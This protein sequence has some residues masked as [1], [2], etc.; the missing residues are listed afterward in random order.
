MK[1]DRYYRAW[2]L[3]ESIY[4]DWGTE[5]FK[6][7]AYDLMRKYGDIFS[8]EIDDRLMQ[9]KILGKKGKGKMMPQHMQNYL[10]SRGL[11]IMEVILAKNGWIDD[12][13]ELEDKAM[14]RG[15][16]LLPIETEEGYCEIRLVDD[17]NRN[18]YIVKSIYRKP[19]YRKPFSIKRKVR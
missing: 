19:L 17:P 2:H 10:K 3:Q 8:F 7:R 13:A 11:R 18:S 14:K 6:N 16:M 5:D 12:L 1:I 4:D 15:K 9:I